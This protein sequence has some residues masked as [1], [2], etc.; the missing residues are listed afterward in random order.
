M[1]KKL[2]ISQI[3]CQCCPKIQ[4]AALVQLEHEANLLL[5]PWKLWAY[6]SVCKTNLDNQQCANTH[7]DN[8]ASCK[9]II[10]HCQH[11][12]LSHCCAKFGR[13]NKVPNFGSCNVDGVFANLWRVHCLQWHLIDLAR[14]CKGA[15]M[16]VRRS[17][18]T[19]RPLSLLLGSAQLATLLHATTRSAL[20]WQESYFCHEALYHSLSG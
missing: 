3:S 7:A 19:S 16:L 5:N 15:N 14:N 11:P 8:F 12:F 2:A 10:Y 18:T 9:H 1:S 20:W 17:F 4:K 6:L 13:F